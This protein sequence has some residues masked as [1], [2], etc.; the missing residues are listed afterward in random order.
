LPLEKPLL[1][2]D[3]SHIVLVQQRFEEPF[4]HRHN[5][6]LLNSPLPPERERR[7]K[8]RRRRPFT[9]R[10]IGTNVA[11]L[12]KLLLPASVQHFAER[13]S[14]GRDGLFPCQQQV[15]ALTKRK[16]NHRITRDQLR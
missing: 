16:T 2:I 5:Q 15:D 12:P 14:T 9:V 6:P 1:G 8:H 11:N 4:L 10:F 7:G 3:S 13:W